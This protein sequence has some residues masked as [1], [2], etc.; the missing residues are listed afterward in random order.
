[1]TRSIRAVL[2]AVLLASTAITAGVSPTLAGCGITVKFVNKDNKQATVYLY[3]SK[4]K[5]KY[6]TYGKLAN[7]T[8][9]VP[10]NGQKSK[11]I[12]LD[13]GCNYDRRY[14]FK[15]GE[16][17]RGTKIIYRPSSTGWTRKTNLTVTINF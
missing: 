15:V 8:V 6:G 5:V 2:A 13:L 9:K 10:A 11:A 4:S 16:S 1:M 14:K 7:G 12:T 3:D 17:G